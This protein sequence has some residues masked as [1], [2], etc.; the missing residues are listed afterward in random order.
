MTSR[1]SCLILALADAADVD[2]F[3]FAQVANHYTGYLP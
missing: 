2:L 1:R 3:D